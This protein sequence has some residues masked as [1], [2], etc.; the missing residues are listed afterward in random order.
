MPSLGTLTATLLPDSEGDLSGLYSAMANFQLE[1]AD[2]QE[3][4]AAGNPIQAFL[5]A[6]LKK[7]ER[8]QQ[9]EEEAKDSEEKNDNDDID[10]DL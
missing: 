6:L 9:E 7:V 4:L 3:A 5:D 1:P 2:G 8:E 10:E